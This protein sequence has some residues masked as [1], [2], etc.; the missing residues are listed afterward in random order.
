M[1]PR[2]A[3]GKGE[4]TVSV[5]YKEVI[6]KVVE[7]EEHC[8]GDKESAERVFSDKVRNNWSRTAHSFLGGNY[9]QTFE[10]TT[11]VHSERREG[12]R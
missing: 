9:Y 1:V 5:T 3:I 2:E 8:N 10:R 6:T 11:V 12:T 4:M 7:E